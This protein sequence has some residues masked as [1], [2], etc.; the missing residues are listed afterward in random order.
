MLL[1]CRMCLWQP[2][3][4]SEN[5]TQFIAM[6]NN[7][8]EKMEQWLSRCRINKRKNKTQ[9]RHTQRSFFSVCFSI[10]LY[11][12]AHV[13]NYPTYMNTSTHAHCH[14]Y[15][16]LH[17][18]CVCCVYIHINT[19]IHIH[20]HIHAHKHIQMQLP[21][22][23]WTCIK[24]AFRVLQLKIIVPVN[25]EVDYRRDGNEKVC[26]KTSECKYSKTE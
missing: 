12:Q 19:A 10:H 25:L 11:T 7:V 2:K 6:K 13:K 18:I 9:I 5:V 1:K 8:R 15:T 24:K 17:V 23:I 21:S 20:F 14:T 3:P 16:N 4:C 26:F 22:R